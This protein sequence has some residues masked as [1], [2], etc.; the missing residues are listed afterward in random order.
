MAAVV[1]GVVLGQSQ[2]AQATVPNDPQSTQSYLGTNGTHTYSTADD[3][4]SRNT[5]TF[6]GPYDNGEPVIIAII[7]DG[8]DFT[9]PD[10]DAK[11]VGTGTGSGALATAI[12]GIAAA[13]TGNLTGIAGVC[14]KCK[15]LSV[16]AAT[17]SASSI[18]TALAAAVTGIKDAHLAAGN[19]GNAQGV[20]VI[21][22]D[23]SLSEDAGLTSMLA[24]IFY[25]R[26]GAPSGSVDASK[27]SI[28]VVAPAGNGVLVDP[29]DATAGRYPTNE[30]SYPCA[31]EASTNNPTDP[32]E[33]DKLVL[34]VGSADV[35]GKPSVFS[36]YGDW[37]MLY[38]PGE[39]ILATKPGGAIETRYDTAAAAAIAAG[40][41]ARIHAVT[42]GTVDNTPAAIQHILL[43]SS[44]YS[45][46]LLAPIGTRYLL[47]DRIATKYASG[48]LSVVA[49]PRSSRSR[50]AMLL[51]TL[52]GIPDAVAATN[53][54][55]PVAQLTNPSNNFLVVPWSSCAVPNPNPKGRDRFEIRGRAIASGG[56]YTITLYRHQTCTTSGS[57]FTAT[58]PNGEP[59]ATLFSGTNPNFNRPTSR[60][61]TVTCEM[62]ALW[63]EGEYTLELK[64][65]KGTTS[66]SSRSKLYVDKSS[67]TNYASPLPLHDV[68]VGGA[69]LGELSALNGTYMDTNG[70]VK[71]VPEVVVG[72]TANKQLHVF[73][74]TT[75]LMLFMSSAGSTGRIVGTPA[76]GNVDDDP[77]N[78][79]VVTAD[80]VGGPSLFVF[81]VDPDDPQTPGSPGTFPRIGP[82]TFSEQIGQVKSSPALGPRLPNNPKEDIFIT[83]TD[84]TLHWFTVENNTLKRKGLASL[85]D[86]GNTGTQ[87]TYTITSPGNTWE[88]TTPQNICPAGTSASC[89]RNLPLME[90]RPLLVGLQ[91][92][93]T[94]RRVYVASQDSFS[95][96]G[97]DPKPDANPSRL[98][99]LAGFPLQWVTTPTPAQP[100]SGGNFDVSLSGDGDGEVEL[101][102]VRYIRDPSTTCSGTTCN[103]RSR[104]S[105]LEVQGNTTATATAESPGKREN[106]NTSTTQFA[107]SLDTVASAADL[108]MYSGAATTDLFPTLPGL[109]TVVV[110]MSGKVYVFNAEA[111]LMGSYQM[112]GRG[113]G[114][115][116]IA[117]LDGDGSKEILA[118]SNDKL[119]YGLQ[120]TLNSSTSATLSLKR[121]LYNSG[122]QARYGFPRALKSSACFQPLPVESPMRQWARENIIRC[123]TP[124]IS[125]LDSD[126]NL[127]LLLVAAAGTESTNAFYRWEF[128]PASGSAGIW[129]LPST[130]LAKWFNFM[131][132]AFATPP[133]GRG[134]TAP[135]AVAHSTVCG[136]DPG[137]GGDRDRPLVTVSVQKQNNAPLPGVFTQ[138]E[139][140]PALVEP[141]PG[142]V[143]NPVKPSLQATDATGTTGYD[144]LGL[145]LGTT[146]TARVIWPMYAT[147]P[148]SSPMLITSNEPPPLT[149][150]IT[151]LPL[152]LISLDVDGNGAVAAPDFFLVL[153]AFG[154]K[155]GDSDWV[156]YERCDVTGDGAVAATDFFLVLGA[157]GKPFPP[158]DVQEG[159][160]LALYVRRKNVDGAAVT[161]TVTGLPAGATFDPATG[162]FSWTPSYTQAGLNPT[163]TFNA[164][165]GGGLSS[166]QSVPL[167][168]LNT[169]LSITPSDTP[170]PFTPYVVDGVTDTTTIS[171]AFNQPVTS[172]TLTIKNKSTG[173]TAR[174]FSY[175]GAAVTSMSQA[176][177][178][179]NASN[180]LVAKGIY[181]YAIS[182]TAQSGSNGGT[183]TTAAPLP[184]VTVQ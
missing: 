29:A 152:P 134:P 126:P 51:E 164:S 38:A 48:D 151:Q 76:V 27:T 58:D 157:F 75:G 130:W 68:V 62:T 5:G 169:L 144:G 60:L 89:G 84:N 65:M 129:Q 104:I 55:P 13:E 1:V 57:C 52:L 108:F 87:A 73:D 166:T 120:A 135:V 113:A 116:L 54:P 117:D 47:N 16:Q 82:P 31:A 21:A 140:T 66:S 35:T 23:Q 176:W 182:A 3:A 160:Q 28:T 92:N 137:C 100:I 40:V 30:R 107:E 67:D 163:I 59:V 183:A 147:T 133:P 101:F 43:S 123:T 53:D 2:P 170:D 121:T 172:W 158:T 136:N 106:K 179:K 150:T 79:V 15:V 9:H 168:V 155:A 81:N 83:T 109:E 132:T 45:R 138:L 105:I 122:S 44:A 125:N 86:N 184:E 49:R 7:G 61:G 78:E 93:V 25:Q 91:A 167:T 175:S 6:N 11:K 102:T 95:M 145:L 112:G 146:V 70:V 174:T 63:D 142:E 34:C 159:Q 41:A 154:K 24:D 17:T 14:A 181:T 77:Y 71:P 114:T 171:A 33:T 149:I 161:N 42:A 139:W 110:G 26:N 20:I 127:E 180:V 162:K 111:T 8:V 19:V 153:G 143:S 118:T 88:K 69:N 94:P 115:P 32:L 37:V 103:D 74:S 39:A 148:V 4:N 96:Y 12:A 97:F 80:A 90:S 56:S 165:A 10:L 131:E 173:V 119:L 98:R 156:Q 124:V 177:N 141:L 72:S 64:V 18:K 36:N 50:V 128:A 46:D 178:G 99:Q 85:T 22:Y